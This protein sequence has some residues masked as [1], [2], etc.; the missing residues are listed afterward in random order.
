MGKE[1]SQILFPLGVSTGRF[2]K[3]AAKPLYIFKFFVLSAELKKIVLFEKII[4]EMLTFKK[5][6]KNSDLI[7]DFCEQSICLIKKVT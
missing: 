1:I 4:L 5:T 3:G 2:Y 7:S 6:T